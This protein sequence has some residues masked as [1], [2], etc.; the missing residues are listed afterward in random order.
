MNKIGKAMLCTALTGAIAVGAAGAADLG[1]LSPQGAKAY[2]NQITTLQNKY[3][4]AAARTDDG[5]QGLLTGL[6][7]AKLVDMD[8]DTIPE[9]YC[10][11]AH[12]GQHM[13]SYADGKIYELIIPKGVI[14]FG[15][16]VSP[17]T[18]FYVGKDKAYLVSGQEVMNNNPVTFWTKQGDKAVV[19]LTYTDGFDWDAET[20]TP[21][22]TINGQS[23]TA[24]EFSSAIL[25]FT[26]DMDEQYYSFWESPYNSDRALSPRAALQDTIASL[27]RLTNPTAKVS[28]HKVTLN[29]E[30]AKLG[31]YTINGSNYFK[32]RDLAKALDGLNTNFEVK[33]N[34]AQQRIDLTSRTAY[35]AVGGEQAALPS[36][37]KAASLTNASVYL[38]GKPLNLTAYSIGGNNY[39]KLR[40]LGDALGFG[41]DW[42]ANTMTMILTVK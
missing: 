35:T 7:M 19:V 11:A 29:G 32:L 26:D 5:F 42:N 34:A 23:V 17:C 13:Y 21:V 40:D 27:R 28:T 20:P 9:L 36:G 2:L 8:G 16:D 30:S 6:S 12:Q 22:K 4:K 24:E 39:F 15:T 33:W 10:A 41:V 31:A 38:D 37:N 1:T 3:G 25:D 14:N 18:Q